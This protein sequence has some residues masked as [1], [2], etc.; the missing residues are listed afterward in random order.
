MVEQCQLFNNSWTGARACHKTCEHGDIKCHMQCPMATPGTV[1][2]LVQL[3]E[4]VVCHK[5]C[6][7]DKSCHKSCKCPF[8]N[9]FTACG[10]LAEAVECHK[11]GGNHE[12]CKMD[13][14]SVDFLLTEPWSLAKDVTNH[15][16]DFLLPPPPALA[17]EQ[18]VHGCHAGCG[19]NHTCHRSCPKGQWGAL[20]ERCEELD[21]QKACHKACKAQKLKCPIEKMSCHMQCPRA[22]PQSVDELR[23]MTEHVACKLDCGKDHECRHSCPKS[24]QWIERKEKCHRYKVVSACHKGCGGDQDCHAQCPHAALAD[25]PAR[26]PGSAIKEVVSTLL[27]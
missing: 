27:I 16:V 22:M 25:E 23:A 26:S 21:A 5:S 17:T 10:N 6:G 3:G 18:E 9:K 8:R 14:E 4:A 19:R 2:E 12:T 24:K 20:K 1:K 13:K 15:V 7:K 11:K